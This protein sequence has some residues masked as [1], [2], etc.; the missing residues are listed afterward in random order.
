MKRVSLLF[1]LILLMN[2]G[3]AQIIY[4]GIINQKDLID[5]IRAVQ[6]SSRISFSVNS[7]LKNDLNLNHKPARFLGK[8]TEECIRLRNGELLWLSEVGSK[9]YFDK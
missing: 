1:C 8:N 4:N 6:N 9:F 5:S 2:D 7:Y 3:F